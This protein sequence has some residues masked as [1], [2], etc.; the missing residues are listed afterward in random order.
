MRNP[1]T[2]EELRRLQQNFERT[3]YWT[4]WGAYLSDRQ[5][6]T[7]REDYS[8]N[9]DAW[10]YF[11]HDHARSRAYRWGEDGLLGLCDNHCRLCFSFALWNERDS[12]LKERPFG[13]TGTEGNHAEDVKEYYYYLDS[14]PTH[15]YLKA[16][17][18]YPQSA[19]P[20]QR[21]LD[22]NRAR[23]KKSP[24]YELEDTGAFHENRYFDVYVEYAKAAPDDI[25]IRLTVA[26][27]GQATAPVHLLPQ[28]WFRNTWVWGDNY[29][30]DWG[31]PSMERQGDLAVLCRHSSL[32]DYVFTAEPSDALQ[33]PGLLFTENETNTDRLFH[34]PNQTPYVKDAFHRYV[35]E[36]DHAAVNPKET[37]TK[38]AAYARFEIPGGSEV[39]LRLR[40]SRRDLVIAAPFGEEFDEIFSRRIAEAEEYFAMHAEPKLTAEER[41][42]VRQAH[43]G[44]QWTK[45]FYYY[46]VRQWIKGDS[47]QPEPPPGRGLIRNGEWQHLFNR[48]VIS[49]PDKWEYPWY[50]VWDSAFHMLAFAEFDPQ[51]AKSQLLLFL[52]EWYMHPNGQIPAYEWDFSEVNPPVHA[53]AAWRVF[54]IEGKRGKRDY[55]FLERVF[56]KL[57]LNFT[58]WVNRKDVS[59]NNIF[60]GGFLGL[61]NIGVFDRSKPIPGAEE[62]AQA[63]ATAWMAFFCSSM[64]SMALELA[65][66][67]PVYEDVASKFFEHFIGIADAMNRIGGHGL[68]DEADGFYYDELI[69]QNDSTPMKIRSL[70]GLIP[71]IAMV[72]IRESTLSRLPNFRRRMEWFLSHRGD[73]AKDICMVH[74]RTNGDKLRLLSMPTED[75]L[76]RQL[77]YMLDENEFLSPFG[78]RSLSKYH[79]RYPFTIFL[80][81]ASHTVSYEPA[82]SESNLFGGNSN[83]RGPIW[84]PINYLLIETLEQ[85]AFYY[86]DAFRIECPIGSGNSMTLQQVADELT[87]RLCRIFDADEKGRAPWHGSSIRPLV[88]EHWREPQLF[89]EYFHGDTGSGLGACHQTGW[90][91][92]IARL[93]ADRARRRPNPDGEGKS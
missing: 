30:A 5:W 19:Y 47:T 59:G 24:E 67:D 56:Q 76:R 87:D 45:Q 26:N 9:G 21:L 90:T 54:Q 40:L 43:A 82:E 68:W 4:R 15:S 74:E 12:I 70:V 34:E 1:G 93:L 13:L 42:I 81:G 10:R 64:L 69:Q 2:N 57:L 63:D 20:Y 86:R 50:A 78:I 31:V 44:L 27:R 38:A 36:G 62:L 18:K 33:K 25:L 3:E 22:E 39:T 32:G 8:A 60:T 73:L 49:M 71:M 61:D 89:Y 75:R 41:N 11:P 92:L 55:A 17:Y 35:V 7:V 52:R 91:A 28:I 80:G 77:Q 51:F 65:A 46:D 6:G 37:G 83:W 29:E 79:Q 16:L 66:Q 23:D 88:D 14:T 58:W 72:V 85:Y 48:D 53:W 84:F